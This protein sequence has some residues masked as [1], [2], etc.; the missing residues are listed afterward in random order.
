MDA[1]NF[2]KYIVYLFGLV[3]EYGLVC[4]TG[5]E[6]QVKVIKQDGGFMENVLWGVWVFRHWWK[7]MR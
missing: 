6:E 1:W 7:A 5:L 4:N 2:N 3:N